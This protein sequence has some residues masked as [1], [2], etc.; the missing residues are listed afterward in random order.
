M[1]RV[2]AS[3]VGRG[4]PLGD[5]LA[6]TAAE[7]EAEAATEEEAEGA[8]GQEL[9]EGLGEEGACDDVKLLLG[10]LEANTGFRAYTL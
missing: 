7:E 10:V 9:A 6:D 8:A 5:E 3:V 4:V 1:K 2:V